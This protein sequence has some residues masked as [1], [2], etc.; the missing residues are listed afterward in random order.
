MY[1]AVC[2][3]DIEDNDGTKDVSGFLSY[4]GVELDSG[5]SQSYNSEIDK[6]I[7]LILLKYRF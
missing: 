7:Q 6:E 1:T 2:I 5:E 3:N 4:D